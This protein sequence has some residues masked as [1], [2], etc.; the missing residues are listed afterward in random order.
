MPRTIFIGDVHGCFY[1]LVELFQKLDVQRDDR[2]V[3]VGDLVDKGPD[4]LGVLRFARNVVETQPGS[5]VVSGNHEEKASRQYK[6]GVAVEPWCEDSIESD[7]AFIDAMP[8]FWY[9]PELN[10]RVVHGGIFPRLLEEHP[11]VWEKIEARGA[12]WQKGGGKVMSRARRMLRIRYVGGP[13][14]PV[15]VKGEV[16]PGEMLE[17]GTNVE[18]DPFWADTYHAEHGVVVYGHAPWLNGKVR[19]RS[20][21]SY[22]IDTACVFG[23]KLTAF[24]IG[25]RIGFVQVRA[26][27]RYAEPLEED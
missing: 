18:G 5:V 4:S 22:G 11:D 16:P 10:I 13:Q 6:R 23:G 8:L 9:D 25:K 7:W 20:L 27:Q 14:R 2:V 19:Q 3:F 26:L 12:N 17:L 24:V 15:G 1:E 21:V